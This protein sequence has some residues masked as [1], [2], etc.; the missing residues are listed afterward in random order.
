MAYEV[1]LTNNKNSAKLTYKRK[2]AIQIA[3]SIHQYVADQGFYLPSRYSTLFGKSFKTNTVNRAALASM[4]ITQLQRQHKQACEAKAMNFFTDVDTG[5]CFYDDYVELAKAF[6]T[7]RASQPAVYALFKHKTNNHYLKQLVALATTK[8]RLDPVW[9]YKKSKLIR[10]IWYRF[11][12]DTRIHELY[13]PMHLMLTVPHKNGQWKGKQFYAK[14]FIAAFNKMRK[15]RGWQRCIYGGEY[16]IEVARSGAD[17]LHIHLHSLVFQQSR[18]LKCGQRRLYPAQLRP[19]VSMDQTLTRDLVNRYI[20]LVWKKL[21]G[22]DVT[23]YET[24][25]VHRK[26]ENDKYI[27]EA[28]DSGIPII[29][30]QGPWTREPAGLS[31]SI[32]TD[33]I[34]G[35]R[36]K[37]Y[38]DNSDPW[39]QTLS[40]DE[41]LKHYCDGVM[42]CIKYHFKN[43]SFKTAKGEWDVELIKD[44]LKHSRNLRMY[45][46]FG[47]FYREKRLN[48]SRLE[49]EVVEP[50]DVTLAAEAV[51][52]ESDGVCGRMINPYT[53]E[54]VTVNS[55]YS[56]V[57]SVPELQTHARDKHGGIRAPVSNK[58]HDIFYKLRPLTPLRE[59]I[60]AIMKGTDEA[61]MQVLIFD[62]FERYKKH[63]WKGER[64]ETVW[65]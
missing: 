48:Y 30:R 18:S 53:K 45:S 6:Y 25:Y 54:L 17:G 51:D 47:A 56:L 44:V 55:G 12:Q 5:E 4:S 24:L 26:D 38:L 36:K 41:R 64:I 1:I 31:Y 50:T 49:K 13:Q 39:F 22:A 8:H 52:P 23:W 63:G 11:L 3:Q 60:A 28:S 20:R 16:G 27:M 43:D 61:F 14:E 65:A 15:S 9:N 19:G 35:K 10:G 33:G 32:E 7:L 37:F 40:D 34:R 21:T 42:E 46:K 59:V 58:D 29:D 62:D 57:L 2:E